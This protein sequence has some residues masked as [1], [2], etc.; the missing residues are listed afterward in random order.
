MIPPRRIVFLTDSAYNRRDHSRFG[1][2]LLEKRGV[3]VEVWDLTSV[4]QPELAA[5]YIPPDTFTFP[6]LKT[7]PS[8]RETRTA[9]SGLRANDAV[10]CLLGYEPS[11]WDLFRA[12]SRSKA[13]YAIM[14]GGNLPAPEGPRPPLTPAR[15]FNALYMRAPMAALGLRPAALAVYLGGEGA[16]RSRHPIGPGTEEIWGHSLDY[17]LY[18]SAEG[19]AAPSGKAVFL[20]EYGPYH[21]DYT[22]TE[23]RPYST[24]EI[25]YA[26]LRG[27][28][29]AFEKA[30]GLAVVVAAHPRSC[31]EEHPDYFGG[32]PVVRGGTIKLVRNADAVIA[33]SSTA[34]A[35]A[36]LYRKPVVF[37][38]SAPQLASPDGLLICAMARSLAKS[39]IDLALPVPAD[40]KEELKTDEAAY[41]DFRRRYIKKDGSP[42]KPFW[43]IVADHLGLPGARS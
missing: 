27:F 34:V 20:D 10:I 1:I 21:P 38:A 30:T 12:L 31:Y 9:L 4:L 35:F 42:E 22:R 14:P 28:F 11:T 19:T 24:P 8:R 15:I 36:V 5:R 16:R 29:D 7:F 37:A 17:D 23:R 40:W 2:E 25:Y 6:G 41:A 33:H 39:V 26:A 18:L 3:S 13:P 32:R 43:D